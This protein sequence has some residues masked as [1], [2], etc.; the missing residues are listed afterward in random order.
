MKIL[1]ITT[2]SNTVNAFLIPH[3]KMLLSQGHQVDIVF[4]IQQEVNQEIID[5]GC[6]V[7]TVKFERSPLNIGNYSAYKDLKK[8]IKYEKYDLIHTHTPV[9]SVVSRLVCKNIRNT[10]VLYTAH[11]F[12]FHKDAPLQNWLIYY[13]IEKWLSRY[14]DCLITIN[15]E[16]YN[17]A[18]NKSF[19]AQEIKMVHGVGIDL[20]KFELQT[21][22]KKDQA[23]KEYIYK[24][25]DFILFYAAELNR[26][27]HQ[28]LLINVVNNLKYK[29]PNI[30][31]L[32]AGTGSLEG[33][34]KELVNKLDLNKNVEFLGFRSDIKNLLMLSDVAVASS[35]REG[36]PVNVMEAMATGLPLVITDVRGHRDLVQNDING[37]IVGVDDNEGFAKSIEKIYKDNELKHRFGLN[38]IKLVQ[39]YSLENVLMEMQEIYT[40]QL[41]GKC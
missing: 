26:N 17:T 35:R 1:F 37:Y 33:E 3:I 8:I 12:H 21:L 10:K 11:G 34:Y 7:H 15:A 5:L 31:L 19:K 24:E 18:V 9:A 38:G 4:N 20:N 23:R 32:L 22:E 6:K 29:I 41:E 14:T 27:K 2:I 40:I 25:D 13:P 36:L 16:D 30:R 28:D 39:Q